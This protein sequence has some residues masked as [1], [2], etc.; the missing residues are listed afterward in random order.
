MGVRR[1]LRCGESLGFRAASF[2]ENVELCL[3]SVDTDREL[4]C[5]VS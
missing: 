3:R 1:K 5:E 4:A 2:T